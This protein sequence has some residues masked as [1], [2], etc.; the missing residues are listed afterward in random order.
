MTI[1]KLINLR[2]PI[3]K[4]GQHAY[5]QSHVAQVDLVLEVEDKHVREVGAEEDEAAAHGGHVRAV[6]QCGDEEREERRGHR[7]RGQIEEQ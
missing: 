6:E 2:T 5:P 7:V 1:I 4:H 3:N